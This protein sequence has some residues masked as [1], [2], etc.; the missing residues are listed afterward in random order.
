M[1]NEEVGRYA[2]EQF[3]KELELGN[4]PIPSVA[5]LIERRIGIG[6]AFVDAP[7]PGHGMTMAREGDILIAVGCTDHP[8]RMRS[9]LAHELGHLRLGSIDRYLTHGEWSKRTPEEIQAD[10]FARHLLVPLSAV[11]AAAKGCEVSESLF[12]DLVQTYLASPI[13]VAIQLREVG[14]ISKE[15]YQEWASVAAGTLASRFG[16]HS[17]Y[18]TLVAQSRRPRA[19]QALLARAIEGYRW[20]VVSAA[21]IARLEGKPSQAAVINELAANGVVPT[22]IPTIDPNPPERSGDALTPEE[23]EWLTGGSD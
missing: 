22:R 23:L 2:A 20:G 11:S 12:S 14:A 3:R 18:Q 13:I 17:E 16:W 6:V 15:T 10:A 7:A 21:A 1:S 19:P 4:A 9:T 5:R 8:M